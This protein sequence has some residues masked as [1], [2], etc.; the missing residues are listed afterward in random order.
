MATI[1]ING[2]LILDQTAGVQAGD[3]DVSATL[4]GLDSD[5]A[6]FLNSLGLTAF[7]K[8]FAALV[9]GASDPD[10]VT[11]T[12][13]LN[14][15]VK[16]LF[17]SD[18]AGND[19]DGD[20]VVGVTLLDGSPLYMWSADGG[21]VVL[22]STSAVAGFSADTIAAAF[23]IESTDATNTVAGVQS[24]T[25]QPLHHTDPNDPNDAVDF[26]DILNISASVVVSKP[27]GDDI[28]VLDDGPDVTIT[29]TAPTLTVD[30]SSLDT[31]AHDDFS[32]IFTVDSG[33][34][35][36]GASGTEY[37]LDTA[38]G[39]SG[40][41][42]VA[43]NL[44]AIL[45]ET[46]AGVIEGRT[47][48][49]DLV[50]TVSV[51]GTGQVTLDQLRA[52]RH[53]PDSGPDQST[54]LTANDL[55]TL[56]ATATDA[57]GDKDHE[58]VGIA[59]S[60]IFK[61]D[62][63][64]ITP[65]GTPP[66]AAVD[67]TTLG[68]AGAAHADYGPLFTKNYGAD[69]GTAISFDLNFGLGAT[70]LADEET[71]QLVVLSKAGGV[72]SGKNT[73]GDTVF[74]ISVSAAGDVVF[75][76]FRS[77]THDP[78]TGP[79]QTLFFA[80]AGL[81]TLTAEITDRDGDK[82]STTL[83]IGKNFSIDDDTITLT[84]PS[85]NSTTATAI[86][87]GN[88]AGQFA[89][90]AFGY[91][92]GHDD[93]TAA[94]YLAGGSDF[95]DVNPNLAGTQITLTGTVNG[96]PVTDITQAVATMTHEDAASADFSWSFHYD[97]DPITAGVQDGTATGTLHFDKAADTFTITDLT[98]VQGFS[99]DVLHTAELTA[100]EPTGNTGHPNIVVEQLS[101]D[102]PGTPVV[103]QGDPFFVQFTANSTTNSVG[104]ITNS[105]GADNQ[106]GNTAWV[107]GEFVANS[108]ADWVSAT[109]TTNGVAG[110]TI[111][112]GELLTLRFFQEN[113]HIVNEPITPTEVVSA[114]ALKFD[115]I[116]N[117]EDLLINLDL[118]DYGAN[119][120][121]GGGDDVHTTRMLNIENADIYKASTPGGV[122]APWTTEFPLDN[123]DG[124]V[125]IE[126]NDYNLAGEHYQIQGMQIMQSANG[127]TGDAFD[128]NKALG[129]AG[130]AT[131]VKH[132]FDPTDNDVLKIVDIGFVQTTSGTQTANLDFA[133]NIA[134]GDLDLLG[135]Q[136]ITAQL[137]TGF[138]V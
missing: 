81:I 43:T 80:S 17:F 78:D 29:G 15:T 45:S 44:E 83:E 128:F 105:T 118:I 42:D 41:F 102:V 99:F 129:A 73:D 95:V 121:L 57:D 98:P 50:F 18:A 33:T 109:Q 28:I 124:L 88:Q 11:V 127:L 24:I 116:G 55:I 31:N 35:G 36:A 6:T 10:L 23:Y 62:F 75:T 72:I 108:H 52:V 111:Q 106:T 74:T 48:G 63:P 37:T 13:G 3:I 136:H 114:V 133:F 97:K 110:D 26:S 32:Q 39:G 67:E 9:D 113:P 117:S 5:F 138:I 84:V 46:G 40:I 92:I 25:F 71:G 47:S 70:G 65:N 103:E 2:Q 1:N 134:D 137:S 22:I 86:H 125:I 104:F 82:A 69:G 76:Q 122:P 96:P 60:L 30:D 58:T 51:D 90:G 119:G 34:D 112:K 64:T 38:G 132:A 68:N 61:D 100:K 77:V 56:T 120:V 93:H 91:D 131:G 135:V 27:I 21:K 107:A 94:F 115:G 66:V 8:N 54:G 49:G 14:E 7:Q 130:G 16:S 12:P 79:D 85:S 87:L 19:L 101:G 20:L 53:T 89:T 59:S 4:G 126:S 123:N